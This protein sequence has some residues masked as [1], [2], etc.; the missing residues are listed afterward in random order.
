MYQKN[1]TSVLHVVTSLNVGGA[2]RFVV[3]LAQEQAENDVEV[4]ILSLGTLS[5]PLLAIVKE[6]GIN[7]YTVEN[8]GGLLGQVKLFKLLLKFNIVHVHSSWALITLS[9]IIKTLRRKNIVYTRHNCDRLNTRK[10]KRIHSLLK[11]NLLG[12]TFVSEESQRAFE[13]N[14]SYLQAP[15]KVIPN[16]VVLPKQNRFLEEVTNNKLRLGSVGRMVALKNQICLLKAV[17]QIETSQN[18]I[19]LHVFGDGEQFDS[20]KSY[21]D[22]KLS[23]HVVNFHGNV[24][25]RETI[26]NNIDI[27]VVTSE[28]EGLSLAIMEAMSYEIPVIATDVGG[29]PELVKNGIN[30]YLFPYNDYNTLAHYIGRLVKDKQELESLGKESKKLIEQ[31]YSISTSAY[32]YRK[33]YRRLSS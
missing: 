27:L 6:N 12:I 32:N 4:S 9:L 21:A 29:N 2:E 19:E 16:G 15:K 5:D 23:N 17:C 7:T 20:L 26:Y 31:N 1:V 22:E 3:D 28:T 11:N 25:D 10:W 8:A 33:I 14:Y 18:E 30:G 24:R 13:E